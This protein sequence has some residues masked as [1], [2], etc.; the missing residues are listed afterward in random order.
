MVELYTIALESGVSIIMR[1]RANIMSLAVIQLILHILRTM[2]TVFMSQLQYILR[3][4]C[5]FRTLP[6]IMRKRANIMSLAVIQLILHILRTMYTVF[7]SQLQYILRRYC[8][9][10][11][12]PLILCFNCLAI[13]GHLVADQQVASTTS[14]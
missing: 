10:R 2:Y 1:K 11:T 9:F 12:L 8:P 3:R 6:L 13:L 14:S 4:Y 7:M 5:P